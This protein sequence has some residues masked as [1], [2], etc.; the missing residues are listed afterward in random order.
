MREGGG[1]VQSK[2]PLSTCVKF[3]S[4]I[5][6]N[7]VIPLQVELEKVQTALAKSQQEV[8]RLQLELEEAKDKVG[9]GQS[10]Q[11]QRGGWK[12][13]QSKH[14]WT[15]QGRVEGRAFLERSRGAGTGR[16]QAQQAQRGSVA[17][18]YGAK[19]QSK[20]VCELATLCCTHCTDQLQQL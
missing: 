15:G 9:E 11:A 14:K 8:Q 13:K 1:A 19:S 10:W 5:I 16:R 6:I 2:A 7:C 20:L 18:I 4:L 12:G 17:G 3:S